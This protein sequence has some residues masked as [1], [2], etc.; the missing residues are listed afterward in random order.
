MNTILYTLIN[1]FINVYGSPKKK[2]E[3]VSEILE[4]NPGLKAVFIG[5]A[6]SDLKV[7]KEHNLDFIYMSKYTVQSK[8]Q[9]EI[10]RREAE[11]VIETLDDLF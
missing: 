6:L 9:D 7:S 5:D 10:C 3:C 8:E 4:N 2:N 11:I 1:Y